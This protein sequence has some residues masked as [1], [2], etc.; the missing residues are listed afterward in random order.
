MRISNLK[1][2]SAFLTLFFAVFTTSAI[3]NGCASD[4]KRGRKALESGDFESAVAHFEA[5]ANKKPGDT[6]IKKQLAEART[7][8]ISA[9][10]ITVRNQR[11]AGNLTDSLETARNILEKTN[12]WD[13]SVSGAAVFTAE[14]ET[15][16]LW[17]DLRKN[18]EVWNQAKT[19]FLSLYHLKRY[20]RIFQS[21]PSFKNYLTQTKKAADVNCN[22]WLVKEYQRVGTGF[23]ANFI[24]KTCATI[25]SN[26]PEVKADIFH[27]SLIT[28]V[29]KS[30]EVESLPRLSR[31]TIV[32]E[33]ES[34]LK[35]SVWFLSTQDKNAGK[36]A[37]LNLF[38]DYNYRVTQTPQ[39]VQKSCTI[40]D[41]KT[42]ETTTVMMSFPSILFAETGRL[43]VKSK[44]E[45][46]Q[47]PIAS[48]SLDENF[49][50]H[51]VTQ[52]GNCPE[53]QYDDPIRYTHFD[54]EK[55][56][57]QKIDS[58]GKSY[59]SALVDAWKTQMCQGENP[60]I[61]STFESEEITRAEN[62]ARCLY[63]MRDQTTGESALWLKN[64]LSLSPV[65]WVQLVSLAI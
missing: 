47:K 40:K 25:H 37:S 18:I 20:E 26:Y 7:A 34:R 49:E 9:K 46:D 59:S 42:A 24:Q 57:Q 15:G 5:A 29:E 23:Y 39:I 64:Q 45:L 33:L 10:W 2:T 17:E 32:D 11:I 4:A 41:P 28:H 53:N 1:T 16:L 30:I 56:L 51:G 3:L 65:Q 55:W 8:W 52:N 22:R 43:L 6:K 62:A 58:I 48:T 36:T 12:L 21:K 14:E 27:G 31:K 50:S 13:Q 54:Q 60:F 19:P 44:T 35:H 63:G 38:T 61:K